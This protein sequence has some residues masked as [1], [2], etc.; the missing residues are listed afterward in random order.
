MPSDTSVCVLLS[1]TP[2]TRH[3]LKKDAVP[4]KFYW[5][6]EPSN[7]SKKRAARTKFH[8]PVEE[9]SASV[10]TDVHLD[11]TELTEVVIGDINSSVY[12]DPAIHCSMPADNSSKTPLWSRLSIEDLSN[13][14]KMLQYYFG[15]QGYHHFQYVLQ[16]LGPAAHQSSG[17]Q[18]ENSAE[19]ICEKP[20]PAH[21]HK[22]GLLEILHNRHGHCQMHACLLEVWW[23]TVPVLLWMKLQ[24]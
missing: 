19:N 24:N 15:L 17:V 5:V 7:C 23:A 21:A 3:A 9:E 4:S 13:D 6:S 10:V 11:V 1:G 8:M 18:V 14:P 22:S 20:A 16:S 12:E 2:R